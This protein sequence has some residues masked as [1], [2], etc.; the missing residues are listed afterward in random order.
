MQT[1]KQTAL[2]AGL[3][4]LVIFITGIYAN[5]MVLEPL[6]GLISQPDFTTL[7]PEQ[8]SGL[9][10]AV[11]SFF[12][13][14]IAD[15]LLTWALFL[16]TRKFNPEK[17]LLSAWLR[18]V[19]VALFAVA[20]KD[21]LLILSSSGSDQAQLQ[22]YLHSF[23]A[24]WLTGLLFFGLHLLVLGWLWQQDT[25][26]MRVIG[27][28]L[29]LAGV[30]YLVDTLAHVLIPNYADYADLFAMLVILPGVVGELSLTVCLLVRGLKNE[31]PNTY[32]YE[33]HD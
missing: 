30:G 24:T 4:Y 32:E 28:L 1:Q 13:M 22:H 27:W 2:L 31:T 25:K 26:I 20:L 21:L 7:L 29:M 14:L 5:F 19:N 8:V 18:L 17:A 33:K 16:L 11:L 10:M 3:G 9:R 15:L 23:D 6:K 12:L